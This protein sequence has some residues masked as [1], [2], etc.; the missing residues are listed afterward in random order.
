MP[1]KLFNTLSRKKQ[2]FKPLR[3]K[4]V[5]L[6]TCGPT[7]YDFAHIG[8]LRTYIFED[9]LRRALKCNGYKVRQVMNI[10]DVEDK[11][12][13]K[14]RAE[15]KNIFAITK[16]YAKIFFDDLKKLNVEKVE[17]Y[18]KATATIKEMTD[19][20]AKLIKRKF[21]YQGQDGSIY[22]DIAKFKN[23]GKLSRLKKRE[24]KIGARIAADEYN[25]KEARDF[26]LWKSCGTDAEENAELRRIKAT[27][28][29]PFGVGRPGWHIECS[30]MSMKYLGTTLDIHAGGVDLIF[31]HHE[32]EIAQSE[33]A[34][35]KK[36]SRFW[37]HGEHLLVDGQKM[38]KSLGNIFT[39]RDLEKR[40]FNPLAFR[41]L[42]LTSHYRSKLN[43]TWKSLEA[44][45]NALNNLTDNLQ[46]IT[47]NKRQTTDDR[48]FATYDKKFL[49]AINDDLNTPKAMAIVWQVVKNVHISSKTKKRFLIKV[50][51]ILGL[52]LN[53][54]KPLEIPPKIA[55]L[56]AQREELR[57]NKQFMQSDALRK[58]IESLGYIIEDTAFGPE[59]RRKP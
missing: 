43:F 17:F 58:K 21:A 41:Y 37:I 25:K 33:A 18:P 13:K 46:P 15:K 27:W 54:I 49:T 51:K 57:R 22:F 11:I 2:V 39:L 7:V 8:N 36:F 28:N 30:A 40:N 45:Q 14:A 59:V 55:Q 34:T 9:I 44:A 3:D 47:Y 42:I 23:Y 35:G 48:K 1:L 5:N 53:K 6:Y 26:V 20:I 50:D 52:G 38:S 19:L 12:I 31:P 24:I 16:P 4:K 10:T 32:N 56:T 29:S